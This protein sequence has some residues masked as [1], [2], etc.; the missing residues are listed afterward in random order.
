MTDPFAGV[1]DPFAWWDISATYDRYA[2]FIDL[3]IYCAIFIALCNAILTSRF[4]GRP[5]K[6]LA[7]T[8]GIAL[9]VSLAV[10]EQQFNWNLGKAAPIAVLLALLLVGFLILHTM[11]RVHISWTIAAPLTYVFLYM[12]IRGVSPEL[13]SVISH[14]APF[15]HLLAAIMFLLCIWRIGVAIWPHQGDDSAG[16]SDAGFVATL[17]RPREKNELKLVKKLKRHMAPE[18]RRETIRLEHSLEALRREAIRQTPDWNAIAQTSS[19]IAHKGDEAIALIDRIRVLDRR[20][21]NFDWQELQ[22]LNGYYQSINDQDKEKLREQITLERNKI[23]QETAIDQIAEAC[24]RRHEDFRSAMNDLGRAASYHD[25]D[26]TVRCINQ[27]A[28]IES[29]QKAELQKLIGAEKR[30]LAVTRTKLREEKRM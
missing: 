27:A 28:H 18:A 7:T 21:R 15:V 13:M 20:I 26:S 16:Q 9:G 2:G 22:Q 5:G 10:V 24:E 4:S 17:D 3:F 6:V 14:R 1:L 11:M 12:F 25:R 30:L 8:L 29:I 23:V 19:H